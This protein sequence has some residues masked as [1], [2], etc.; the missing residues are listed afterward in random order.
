MTPYYQDDLAYIHHVGFGGFARGAAPGVLA[1]LQDAGIRDGL[2]V[3]LGCGS[4][5]W[6]DVLTRHGYD[7]LGIDRAP[8]MVARARTTAPHATFVEASLHE[9]PLPPCRAVTALGEGIGYVDPDADAAGLLDTLVRRVA[10]ALAP[11]GLFVFDL[12]LRGQGR[13][14]AYRSWAAGDDWAVLVEV[15]P[16]DDGARLRR[17]ITTFREIGTGY[18][19]GAETHHVH[20][21]TRAEVEAAL[22]A[23]G[24][25]VRA[26]R[27]Y[28]THALAPGRMAFR[29]RRR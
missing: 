5:I 13:Q 22:R 20:R 6:A 3:D 11:G 1:M 18:R 16:A 8:A 23:A 9:A 27:R 10:A 7:V 14:A 24:F 21:F 28:G 17:N 26:L 15:D 4:G 19:R 25:T 2:V 12:L 29:A